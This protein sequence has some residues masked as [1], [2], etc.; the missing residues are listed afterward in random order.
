M[1]ADPALLVPAD[2]TVSEKLASWPQSTQS[3][4]NVW[5]TQTLTPELPWGND[6]MHARYYSANLGRF[7]SVDPV[8]GEIGSSQSWNRYSYVQNNPVNLIDPSG[9]CSAP[10]GTKGGAVGICIEAFIAADRLKPMGGI[11]HGDNRGHSATEDLTYRVRADVVLNESRTTV[12]LT[13]DSGVSV[14]GWGPA[15]VSN[16]GKD[17][18]GITDGPAAD[19][20][21]NVTFTVT[22]SAVNGFAALP[23]APKESIDA[24][25]TFQVGADGN[26]SLTSFEHD[27]Y[28]SYGVYAY[29]EGQDPQ[30]LLEYDE[31]EL[32]DLAPPMEVTGP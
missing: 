27:G 21:G 25:F 13:S 18:T 28:P 12:S 3:E 17:Q 26:V 24:S 8:G 32:D 23:G 15:T 4:A 5:E 31:N 7:L 20:Q 14:V 11:G 2:P 10:A 16:P 1:R 19:D 9:K 29:Q 30:V 22:T 6:S